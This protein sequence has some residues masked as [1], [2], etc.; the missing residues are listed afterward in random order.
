LNLQIVV[1]GMHLDAAHGHSIN[2]IRREGWKI[3]GV[4]PWPP[5]ADAAS[6]AANVGQAIMALA[7]LFTKLNPSIVLIVGDR[8]EAFAAAAAGHLGGHVVAHVHGGDRALG[9]M[10][11]TLRHAIAKLAHIHFPATS[12]SAKRLERLGENA[13]RIHAVGSPGI[14]SIAAAASSRSRVAKLYPDL[15]PRGYA[16]VLLH[17]THAD[18]AMEYQRAKMLLAAVRSARIGRALVLYPNND[19]GSR[20][21]L[22]AWREC[23]DEAG[24]WFEKDLTRPDFLGL[25]RD[26]AL[27]VGNS[28]SGI[29]EAASFGTPVVDVGDRQAGRERSGNV[30]N[31]SF[32]S[33]SL[34]RTLKQVWN[35]G[36][37]RRWKGANVYGGR[38]TG[39]RMTAILAG[40]RLDADLR[41]KLITY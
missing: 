24:W 29:I 31:V 13:W 1:T 35:E 18:D 32:E 30:I 3:D 22:R 11:D 10:D 12:A 38:G 23:R 20:G 19:P 39:R 2:Q 26:A 7:K 14:D 40:I 36:N 6:R 16:L 28:S 17:P 15:R 5:T 21:I 27:L 33:A 34:R 8:V 37:P 25:L 4:I 9:Q 41:R